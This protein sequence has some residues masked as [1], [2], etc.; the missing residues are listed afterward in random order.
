MPQDYYDNMLTEAYEHIDVLTLNEGCLN[1]DVIEVCH[2]GYKFNRKGASC[3]VRVKYYTYANEWSNHEHII[4]A[5]SIDKA[6]EKYKRE[7]GR[8]IDDE[9]LVYDYF[10]CMRVVFDNRVFA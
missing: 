4:Y 10:D 5:T 1:D 8:E 2:K 6:I 7:T 9:Y 3:A